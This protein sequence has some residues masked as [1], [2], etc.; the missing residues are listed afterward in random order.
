VNVFKNAMF[1]F[2]LVYS[3]LTPLQGFLNAIVYSND[4]RNQL[5]K[6][7]RSLSFISG[8]RIGRTQQDREPEN[9][10]IQVL[11]EVESSETKIKSFCPGVTN[12]KVEVDEE[13]VVV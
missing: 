6:V 11:E 1:D 13:T 4:L 8:D 9:V 7:S 5:K 3:I 12:M 2:A 10:P